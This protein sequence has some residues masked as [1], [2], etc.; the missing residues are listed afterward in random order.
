[1]DNNKPLMIIVEGGDCSGKTSSLAILKELCEAHGKHVYTFGALNNNP[2]SEDV[3][4]IYTRSNLDLH[5]DTLVS[6][7]VDAHEATMQQILE[8]TLTI[9]E[10]DLANSVF[11]VDRFLLSTLAYQGSDERLTK[12]IHDKFLK[13]DILAKLWHYDPLFFILTTDN[14]VLKQRLDSKPDK[15]EFELKGLDFHIRIHNYYQL[16]AGA[17]LSHI[18]KC[19]YTIIQTNDGLDVLRNTYTGY[20]NALFN[21]YK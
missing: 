6:L 8:T 21:N 10:A 19:K 2:V 11:I 16:V 13:R 3:R 12:M 1:M 5:P 7:L 20:L 4:K 9:P 18:Y 17:K 15:D 14:D